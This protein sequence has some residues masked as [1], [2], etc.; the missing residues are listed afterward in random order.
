MADTDSP[1]PRSA[2]LSEL[3]DLLVEKPPL[4]DI[5]RQL[6]DEPPKA[7]PRR[8]QLT[9]NGSRVAAAAKKFLDQINH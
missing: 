5:L 8:S 4:I 2:V 7:H 3:M 6:A 9:Y 1:K